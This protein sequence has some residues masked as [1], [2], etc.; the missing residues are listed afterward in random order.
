MNTSDNLAVCLTIVYWPFSS[1]LKLRN[2]QSR[3]STSAAAA[4][5]TNR[6]ASS[7]RQPPKGGGGGGSGFGGFGGFG[8]DGGDSLFGD[9]QDDPYGLF[10]GGDNGGGGGDP[11]GP[12]TSQVKHTDED[13]N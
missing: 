13:V 4:A 11:R 10:G 12:S 7:Q 6:S 2:P 3:P 8:G 9:D 5:G 1:L